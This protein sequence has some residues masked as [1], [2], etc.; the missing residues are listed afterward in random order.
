MGRWGDISRPATDSQEEAVKTADYLRGNPQ[1]PSRSDSL[2]QE[3]PMAENLLNPSG[4]P[5]VDKPDGEEVQIE[6]ESS[7]EKRFS[8]RFRYSQNN[9]GRGTPKTKTDRSVE[10]NQVVNDPE[11]VL[12]DVESGKATT[13]PEKGPL[14]RSVECDRQQTLARDQ[15]T[16]KKTLQSRLGQFCF[17]LN[18]I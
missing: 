12:L 3:K 5:A 8:S 11:V 15:G 18:S 17:P 13:H 6:Y 10:P 9:R 4:H 14:D 7:G 1:E 2:S 16:N